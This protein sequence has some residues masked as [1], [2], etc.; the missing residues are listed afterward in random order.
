MVQ[1]G[2][3]VCCGKHMVSRH[4]SPRSGDRDTFD[5][6]MPMSLYGPDALGNLGLMAFNCN[7][8]KGGRAPTH[9]EC[10]ALDFINQLLGWP[11]PSVIYQWL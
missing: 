4:R 2:R 8:R 3:C 9:Y 11:T 7:Q 6:I 5:H 1:E 10:V